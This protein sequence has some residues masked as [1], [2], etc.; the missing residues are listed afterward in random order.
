M[1]TFP[2]I[3]HPSEALTPERELVDQLA[4]LR[5]ELALHQATRP[6]DHNTEALRVWVRAKDRILFGIE[7]A[8][9]QIRNRWR[10]V[11]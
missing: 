3:S 9:G 2:M 1:T 7:H 6:G 5:A 8:E 10:V 4:T 11:A